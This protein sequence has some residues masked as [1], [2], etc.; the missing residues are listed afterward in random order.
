MFVRTLRGLAAAL[1][2]VA[3]V[4]TAA[5]AQASSRAGVSAGLSLPMGDWGDVVGMGFT[6]GGQYAFALG[7][8]KASLRINA[9]YS[10]FGGED[11]AGTDNGSMIGGVVNVVYPIQASAAWKPYIL[12]GLGFYQAKV[13]N[14]GG[15]S[16]DDSALAFNVG[17]GYEFKLGNSNLFTE[18]RYL[19]V[20]TDGSSANTL[21]IVIGL[22]F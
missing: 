6:V 8:S 14:T 21:P 7:S 12:G 4:T 10:R 2:L 17:A 3:A 16:N 5:E 19:S 1:I 11:A 15:G 22:R 13:E 20:Q 9:D 18:V